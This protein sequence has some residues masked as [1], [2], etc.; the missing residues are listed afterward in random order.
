MINKQLTLDEMF[1]SPLF[2]GGYLTIKDVKDKKITLAAPNEKVFNEILRMFNFYSSTQ[3][4]YEKIQQLFQ[5]NKNDIK[6]K[7]WWD[8]FDKKLKGVIDKN[9]DLKVTKGSSESNKS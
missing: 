4:L 2:Y 7:Y 1:T 3:V 8:L 5:K 6:I 9:H